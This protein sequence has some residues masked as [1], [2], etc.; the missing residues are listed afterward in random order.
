LALTKLNIYK[1]LNAQNLSNCSSC[2][3]EKGNVK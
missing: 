3:A 1:Q 2:S